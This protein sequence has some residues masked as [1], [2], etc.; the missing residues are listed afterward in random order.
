MEMLHVQQ[1]YNHSDTLLALA[2]VFMDILLQLK[3]GF[4]MEPKI[5][6]ILQ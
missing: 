2:T 4:F 6:H 3:Q 1:Q 5:S